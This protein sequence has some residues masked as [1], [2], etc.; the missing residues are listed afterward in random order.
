MKAD[1]EIV[2]NVYPIEDIDPDF[3]WGSR[4]RTKPRRKDRRS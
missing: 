3:R 4:V 2:G 1:P